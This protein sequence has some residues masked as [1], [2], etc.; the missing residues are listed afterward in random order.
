M[1]G[2]SAGA[3]VEDAVCPIDHAH[4]GRYTMGSRPLEVEVLQLFAGQAP[5][6]L[7]ELQAATDA[8]AWHMAAHTLKGSA[9]AVGAFAVA[10]AAERAERAGC[11]HPER[12]QM[13]A[14][15]AALLEEARCYIDGLK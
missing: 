15:V 10:N 7:A 9:R 13:V 3:G 2:S 14:T 5:A 11:D 6:T 8:K 4:L 12:A 1:S